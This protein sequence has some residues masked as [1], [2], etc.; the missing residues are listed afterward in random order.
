[1]ST[2]AKVRMRPVHA[3]VSVV[4]TLTHQ[5]PF[6][7]PL[8]VPVRHS[9]LTLTDEQPWPPRK[10]TVG[11]EWQALDCGWLADGAS[12]FMLENRGAG[13]RQTLPTKEERDADLARVVEV[14]LWIC[15]PDDPG[16]TMH[17]PP[18]W[19]PFVQPFAMVRPGDCP[20]FE[21]S[22]L[23]LLRVRCQS[24]TAKCVLTLFPR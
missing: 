1:M 15:P 6:G 4:K 7:K 23:P 9:R 22:C 19:E 3:K 5:E 2:E 17:S 13:P 14:G 21:P 11:G 8:S 20:D 24:G 10:F 16:R 18:R 12:R